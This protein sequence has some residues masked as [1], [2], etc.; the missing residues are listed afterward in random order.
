MK[1]TVIVV[2][3]SELIRNIMIKAL[4]DDYV[5]LEAR[6]GREAI[7]LVRNKNNTSYDMYKEIINN[8]R[9]IIDDLNLLKLQTYLKKFKN[10]AKYLKI[11]QEEVL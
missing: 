4:S 8:Y 6:D 3:D 5:V 7:E 9:Q 10:S 1:N 11:I 2:D